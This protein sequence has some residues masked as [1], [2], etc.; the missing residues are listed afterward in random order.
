MRKFLFTAIALAMALN[1]NFTYAQAA[2]KMV[3][4]TGV[5]VNPVTGNPSTGA[6]MEWSTDGITFTTACAVV[7]ATATTCVA[8][9]IATGPTFRF[10]F[11]RIG[12]FADSLPSAV[13]TIGTGGPDAPTAGV[14]T[15]SVQ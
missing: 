6:R 3:T 9:P 7:T 1:S 4:F 14:V 15:F 8:A 11:V 12:N 5:W 10:R 13:V 2:P